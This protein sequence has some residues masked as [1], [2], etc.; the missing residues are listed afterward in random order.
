MKINK[1][2]T[3]RILQHVFFWVAFLFLFSLVS[4]S[5]NDTFKLKFLI[6][7][8]YLP[9]FIPLTYFN[10]YFI[11]PRYLLTKKYRLFFVLFL[12]TFIGDTLLFMAYCVYFQYPLLYNANQGSKN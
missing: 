7:L 5:S 3:F 11:I 12:I 6:T 1:N 10:I 2:K 8:T 9:I 4:G